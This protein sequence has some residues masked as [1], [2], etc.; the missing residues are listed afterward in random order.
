MPYM[1]LEQ[2]IRAGNSQNSQAAVVRSVLTEA[3]VQFS[4]L[5]KG[6]IFRHDIANGRLF[7]TTRVRFESFPTPNC[8]LCL[9][10]NFSR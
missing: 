8:A 2:G 1:K 3:A 6:S 9:E 10:T 4:S 5:S 7:L